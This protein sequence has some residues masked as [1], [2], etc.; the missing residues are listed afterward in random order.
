M[1]PMTV[2]LSNTYKEIGRYTVSNAKF[3]VHRVGMGNKHCLHVN[4]RYAIRYVTVKKMSFSPIAVGTSVQVNTDFCV[5]LPSASTKIVA[6]SRDKAILCSLN[7][8][9]VGSIDLPVENSSFCTPVSTCWNITT[10]HLRTQKMDSSL[11]SYYYHNKEPGTKAMQ[12]EQL[13]MR[14]L[15]EYM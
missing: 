12:I 11:D 4:V 3:S 6:S 10:P 5:G 2:S 14:L 7:R 8:A 9:M 15:P 13:A 1:L